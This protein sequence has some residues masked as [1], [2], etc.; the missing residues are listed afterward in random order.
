MNTEEEEEEEEEE[1]VVMMQTGGVDT[2][3]SYGQGGRSCG[4]E[5]GAALE[6]L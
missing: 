5:V 1:D 2:G 3:P 6:L 4:K